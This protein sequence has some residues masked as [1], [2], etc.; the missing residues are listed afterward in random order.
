[1]PKQP[2]ALTGS[3]SQAPN[4]R[5]LWEMAL[6]FIKPRINPS[7]F[8]RWFLPLRCLSIDSNTVVVE[9]PNA[10]LKDWFQE[11]F[12][13]DLTQAFERVLDQKVKVRLVLAQPRTDKA[14]AIPRTQPSRSTTDS[15]K[16]SSSP[17]SPP[18]GS[19]SLPE[20][21]TFDNFVVG[22]SNQLAEAAARSVA[23][24]PASRYNPLFLYGGVGLG[25]THL[26]CAIGHHLL[27]LHPDWKVRYLTSDQF[28]NEFVS[29]IKN[30]RADA[31]RAKYRKD[32]D[33]LLVDDIQF[34]AGKDRTQEEFFHVFNALY[35]TGKQIVVTSDRF[36]QEIPGLEDRLRTRFQ[37]G[38]I[39]DIQ[40]PE[41]ETR[42]AIVRKKAESQQMSLSEEVAEF[43]AE[44]ITDNVRRLEGALV[45]LSAYAR[46]QGRSITVE[47]TEQA[48][49]DFLKKSPST[50]TIDVILKEVSSLLD[51]K[52]ADIKGRRRHKKVSQARQVAMYLSRKLTDKSYPDIGRAFGGKD[53]STV[54]AA[55]KKVEKLL[56][57]DASTR[58]LVDMLTE[59]LTRR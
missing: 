54:V 15:S 57:E 41:L 2:S 36:P 47:F 35:E 21:Y 53:H 12:L 6:D 28:I 55:V 16:N 40:P 19:P 26:L 27:A 30:D 9:A 25:K 52:V 5:Q 8:S 45:L 23:Q 39:A 17:S 7:N 20:R 49:R 34:L 48:L 44:N 43:L 38:L 51:V 13:S 46:L 32:C 22:P 29:H 50:L 1:M 24:S 11:N 59:K 33:I 31:F 3:Q 42:K 18:S 56:Q 10:Y 37:W 58:S 14:T 4:T